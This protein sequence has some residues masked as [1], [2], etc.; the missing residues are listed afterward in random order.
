MSTEIKKFEELKSRKLPREI[1]RLCEEKGDAENQLRL[2]RI[3]ER[4]KWKRNMWKFPGM[5]GPI[6]CP[7]Q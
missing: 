5:K 1:G 4:R 7:H 2:S 3:L 6:E